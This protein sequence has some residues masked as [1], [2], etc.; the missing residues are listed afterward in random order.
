MKDVFIKVRTDSLRKPSRVIL[1][2]S[3]IGNYKEGSGGPF[4]E[5]VNSSS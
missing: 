5:L 3:L 2:L 1:A 4:D